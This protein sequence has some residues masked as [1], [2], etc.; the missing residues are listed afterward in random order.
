MLIL[1]ITA[2]NMDL[3]CCVVCF[4]VILFICKQGDAGKAPYSFPKTGTVTEP[5]PSAVVQDCCKK[6]IEKECL[7]ICH[8][9]HD[10]RKFHG[11]TV[12]KYRYGHIHDGCLRGKMP[13]PFNRTDIPSF[14]YDKHRQA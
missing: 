13:Q 6:Y 3:S 8:I 14:V 7:D 10:Q 9:D 1:K 12:C 2:L 5:S 11:S 4:A